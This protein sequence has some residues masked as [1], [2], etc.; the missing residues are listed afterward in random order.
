M[1]YR[2]GFLLY[3]TVIEPLDNVLLTTIPTGTSP[4]VLT[5]NMAEPADPHWA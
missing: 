3:L 2:W 4:E 5:F 1:I